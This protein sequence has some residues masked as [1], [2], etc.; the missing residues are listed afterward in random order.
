MT[1]DDLYNNIVQ[2]VVKFALQFIADHAP[3]AGYVNWDA[4]SQVKELPEDDVLIGPAGVGMSHEMT[5][6]I[7]VI[8]SIGV[9][10]KSDP[11]LFKLTKLMSKLYGRLKPESRVTIYD[12]DTAAPVSWMVTA[13]PLEVTPV[14]KAEMRSMQFIEVRALIDPGATSSLR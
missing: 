2:S 7:E 3:E 13:T 14:S 11:N 8:F 9:C 12:H 10:T 4:H 1:G 6:K 5:D